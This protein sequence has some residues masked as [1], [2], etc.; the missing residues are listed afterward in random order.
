MMNTFP[1][2]LSRAPRCKLHR[3]PRRASCSRSVPPSFKIK[4]V[5]WGLVV[6]FLVALALAAAALNRGIRKNALADSEARITRFMA[7]AEAALNRALLGFDVLLASTDDLLGLSFSPSC[8][9]S[10]LSIP[11]CT[12]TCGSPRAC[13]CRRHWRGRAAS[14]WA[15]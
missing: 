14:A 9:R 6:C 10:S 12:R 15:C 13:L 8:L 2:R 5:V 11:S 4:L 3:L 7:G 1:H